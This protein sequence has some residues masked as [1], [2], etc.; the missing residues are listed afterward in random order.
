MRARGREYEERERGAG[1]GRQNRQDMAMQA[2]QRIVLAFPL[3]P[4]RAK[5]GPKLNPVRSRDSCQRV[6]VRGTPPA[7]A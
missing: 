3:F 5:G 1:E 4:S 2:H 6:A 7:A